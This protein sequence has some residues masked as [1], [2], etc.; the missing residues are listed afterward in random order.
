[1]LSVRVS[2]G[3]FPEYDKAIMGAETLTRNARRLVDQ[4]HEA[5]V[6]ASR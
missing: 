6:E 2:G 1:M 5:R 3:V 4:G